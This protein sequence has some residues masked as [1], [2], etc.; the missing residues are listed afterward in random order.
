M[1]FIIILVVAIFFAYRAGWRSGYVK[2]AC[3][4]VDHFV[5]L[6]RKDKGLDLQSKNKSFRIDAMLQ[7]IGE[8]A[9]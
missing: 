8:A 5:D 9:E 6:W 7:K 2:G 3:D 4:G 1:G